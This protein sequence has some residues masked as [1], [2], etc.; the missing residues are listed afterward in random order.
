MIWKSWRGEEE[1]VKKQEKWRDEENKVAECYTL[2][3][4]NER[5]WAALSKSNLFKYS[6]FR[7]SK[8]KQEK[9]QSNK[10][11]KYLLDLKQLWASE[12]QFTIL[13]VI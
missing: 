10:Y 13:W 1:I 9:P 4:V 3:S 7:N 5:L 8:F 12:K 11:H 6:I 2:I